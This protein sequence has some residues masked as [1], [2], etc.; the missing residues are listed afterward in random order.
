MKTHLVNVNADSDTAVGEAAEKST[1]EP[2]SSQIT[3]AR[4]RADATKEYEYCQLGCRMEICTKE[5][6]N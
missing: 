5:S 2:R 1:A 4:Q 3:S 6:L